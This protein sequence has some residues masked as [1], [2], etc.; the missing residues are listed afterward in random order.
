MS[1]VF[2]SSKPT[3]QFI[4]ADIVKAMPYKRL[5][6]RIALSIIQKFSRTANY[7]WHYYFNILRPELLNY[8]KTI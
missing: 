5:N 2:E 4:L 7:N 8:F 6:K 3:D 1:D